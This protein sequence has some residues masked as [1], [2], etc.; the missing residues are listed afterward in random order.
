MAWQTRFGP[1][2][3]AWDPGVTKNDYETSVQG[4]E[5]SIKNFYVANHCQK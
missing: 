1:S 5:Y 3:I 4:L 2:P